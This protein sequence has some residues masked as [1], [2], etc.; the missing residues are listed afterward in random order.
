[1]G[2]TVLQVAFKSKLTV[3]CESRLDSRL[4]SYANR[5]SRTS[6]RESSRGSSLA[7]QKTKDSPA[8]DFSIILQRREAVTQQGMVIFAQATV[9]SKKDNSSCKANVSSRTSVSNFSSSSRVSKAWSKCKQ[10]KYTCAQATACLF[11]NVNRFWDYP[12]HT[13]QLVT[14][15]PSVT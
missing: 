8:T 1:M 2:H 9:C 13:D 3:R 7:G 5:E 4:D 10:T 12:A 14:Y 6:Y 15:T 11:F